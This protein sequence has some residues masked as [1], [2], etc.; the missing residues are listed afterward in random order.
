MSEINVDLIKEE[1]FLC[2]VFFLTEQAKN[3][4]LTK[5][6]GIQQGAGFT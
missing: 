2:E 6:L 4:A 3:T 5:L 1:F